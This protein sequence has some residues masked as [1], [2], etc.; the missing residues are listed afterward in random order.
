M[1][2]AIAG[3]G[4]D[5][6]LAADGH[7]DD[8]AAVAT[9]DF[10]HQRGC[11]EIGD[12]QLAGAAGQEVI[13]EQREHHLL[14]D[15]LALFV[16]EGD[17]VGIDIEEEGGVGAHGADQ[18]GQLQADS[19]D[20]SI[21]LVREGDAFNLLVDEDELE[22][23][24]LVQPFEDQ[25][26]CAVAAID[27]H[28]QMA[29]GCE[30]VDLGEF[31]E[32]MVEGVA[33]AVAVT[34]LLPADEVE[35]AQVVDVEQFIGFRGGEIRSTG[36]EE[37]QGIPFGTVVAGADGD[38]AGGREAADGVL[39]DRGG[40]DAEVDDIA[41]AGHQGGDDAFANH[42]AGGAGVAADDDGAGRLQE[43]AEGRGE[44]EHMGGGHAG[45]DHATQ[46][47]LRDA[48]RTFYSHVI[49]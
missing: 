1:L 13:G 33:L 28:L 10:V 29:Q 37:L 41:A 46:A 39:D 3:E 4:V 49:S 34:D 6:G 23:E 40:D 24:A 35:A 15:G 36:A 38:A 45:A 11:R 42:D 43:G 7:S 19:R 27:E 25:R 5:G 26:R 18:R 12:D 20:R 32:V 8:A 16:G 47:Y 31:V 21:G 30:V 22:A 17:A 48:E 9:G 2:G 14:G 44:V